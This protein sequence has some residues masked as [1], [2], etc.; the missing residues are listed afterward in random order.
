MWQ[1]P[2]CSE[3]HD[4][5]FDTCW[6]CGSDQVGGRNPDYRVS[7]Q[8]Q[9]TSADFRPRVDGRC[10]VVTSG[11]ILPACCVKSNLPVAESEVKW[12]RLRW[13]SPWVSLWIILSGLLLII[14]YFLVRKNCNLAYGLQPNIRKK[15]RMWKM[16]KIL[17]VFVLLFS[18]PYSAAYASTSVM[19]TV[20]IL[21]FAAVVSLFFGNSPLY[22]QSY[23]DGLF[24]IGGF[25]EE[26]LQ[27]ISSGQ[28]AWGQEPD[29]CN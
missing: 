20:F 26:Y 24:W 5:Q 12:K 25:S 6:K 8:D 7:E 1:C 10:L 16:L 3:Q 2:N 28:V 9:S 11:T 27:R 19:L 21:F 17:A 29:T 22:V 13:C 15:Y 14:A 23:K 18:L 4:D